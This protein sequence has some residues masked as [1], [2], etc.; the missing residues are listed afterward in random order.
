M[1]TWEAQVMAQPTTAAVAI[2]PL[3][4]TWTAANT[5]DVGASDARAFL[6]RPADARNIGLPTT[7]FPTW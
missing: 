1:N 6:R 5:V 7:P 4:K 2:D 3:F